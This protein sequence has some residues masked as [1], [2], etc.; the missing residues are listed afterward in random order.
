MTFLNSAL[1]AGLLPLLALPLVIHLLNKG[2]PKQFRFPS[3]DLI[4]ET[5]ARR[6]KVHQWR[7]WILLL[8]R[9]VFLALLLLAFLLPVIKRFNSNPAG[10]GGRH[11]LIVLDHSISMEH[12]GDGPTA[13]ERAMHEAAKLINSLDA[14]D[15]VN[16]LLLRS[17]PATC[18]VD[19]SRDHSEANRFI[20]QLKPGFTRADVNL[21]NALAARLV[22]KEVS[23]PE[24]Y[25][26][27]DFQRKNWANVNFTALPPAA[28]LF[29]VDTGATRRDNRAIL[30][31]RM[32]Q[33]QILAGDTVALEISV[34]NFSREPFNGN[35]TV[36]VDQRYTFDQEI[37][38]APWSEG[39]ATVRVPAGGPG[40]HL[41]EVRLPSDALEHDNHFRLTL[42]VQEKEE[43]LIVSDGPNDTRSGAF[44]L[45]TALNPFENDT[46]SLLPRL[47]TS[48]EIS[49]SRLAGVRKV[50]FTQINRLSVEACEA[51]A[52]FLFQGGGLVYFLDGPADAE[53][54][55]ALERVIGPETMPL[56]LAEMHT[57]SNV[58][59]GA[60]QVV[61]GDFKSRYLKLF[62]GAARQNLALLE[63]YDYYRAGAT[64]AGSVL[65]AYGDDSPAMA[66]LHHGLGTALLLNFSVGEFSSNL[67]RQ[68]IFPAWMQELVKAVSADE[69]LPA[70][71]VIGETLHAEVWRSEMRD[72]EF[73]NPAGAS[74]TIKRVPDGERYKVTFTPDQLGF[75]TL[76]APR[77]LYAFGIN[78]SAD[79]ADLRPIDKDALPREFAA[80]REAHFVAGADDFDELARGR[81]LFHWFIL[82]GVAVLLCESGFQLFLRRRT[83]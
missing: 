56:R 67:A 79:E 10:Q 27:S 81:P 20:N 31:A 9:T 22:S 45:R 6:S 69:P 28:R 80:G 46:G 50:F 74:V 77:L 13:R 71:H 12:R 43:V 57:A 75:Y 76:G 19:F 24:I 42:A 48:G 29:F 21:A 36:T 70:A 7:H 30:D 11:V 33:T 34:G 55:A 5:M 2:F 37:S 39:R 49:P 44:F 51:T 35:I 41:C 73:K 61:R 1:F 16:V 82:A 4:K 68:R 66:A 14:D 25:Y 38:I 18:F 72:H 62:S 3:V 17:S 54:L 60:Q 78:T 53:N 64:G 32:A 15:A 58:V 8:L 83:A 52:R 59:S 63:F 65:L 40:L 47:I 23:R 26:I